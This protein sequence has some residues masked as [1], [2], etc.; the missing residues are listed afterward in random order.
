M[1][2][3]TKIIGSPSAIKAN[4]DLNTSMPLGVKSIISETVDAIATHHPQYA[5]VLVEG[6]GHA[7]T[8]SGSCVSSSG[9]LKIE[10]F[11]PAVEPK[12]EAAPDSAAPEKAQEADTANGA[13]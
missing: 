2:W 13:S 1:S 4:L 11:I 10:P 6:H 7:C 8:G 9:L 5:I 3:S 12:A